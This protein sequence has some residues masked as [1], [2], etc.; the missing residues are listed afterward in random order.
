M[1]LTERIEEL[2]KTLRGKRISEITEEETMR[3]LDLLFESVVYIRQEP[4]EFELKSLELALRVNDI[5]YNNDNIEAIIKLYNIIKI[6]QLKTTLKDIT[7]IP[8]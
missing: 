5:D 3:L 8:F 6:N 1:D 7:L 2:I 4:T